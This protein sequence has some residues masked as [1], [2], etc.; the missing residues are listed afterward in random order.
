MQELLE[1]LK[2]VLPNVDW[3]TDQLLVDDGILDSMDIISVISEITDEYDVKISMDDM[4]PENF[5][6]VQAMHDMITRLQEE[7]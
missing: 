4:K 2:D 3:E 6:S 1:F 5:N 7:D